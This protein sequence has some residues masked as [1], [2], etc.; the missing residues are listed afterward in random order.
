[1][2]LLYA[3]II[4]YCCSLLIDCSVDVKLGLISN[5]PNVTGHLI[6]SVLAGLGVS[7]ETSRSED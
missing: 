1:M 2:C 6:V 3:V 7:S 4:V 5:Y